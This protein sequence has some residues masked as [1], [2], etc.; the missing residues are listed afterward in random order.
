MTKITTP[1]NPR[2]LQLLLKGYKA[3]KTHY[4]VNGFTFGFRIGFV[5]V[6]R[7]MH[8]PN[9]KSAYTNSAATSELL[10]KELAADRLLGPFQKIPFSTAF[11][12]PLSVIPKKS[13]N[14]FRLIHDLSFP[15]NQ[16]VNSGIPPHS[17]TVHYESFDSAIKYIVTQG[18]QVLLMKCD[19]LNAFRIVPV[20]PDDRPLLG[21]S[22][23][24]K[25][26]F[27]KCLT[28]GCGSSCRIFEEFST[29]IKF[30]LLRFI[31]N[32]HIVKV[33]DDFLIITSATHPCPSLAYRQMFAVFQLLGV[34]L[35]LDKCVAPCSVLTFLGLE[36]NVI[37]QSVKLPKDK[38]D[39]CLGAVGRL[40]QQSKAK[41]QQV[42]SV[43]GLLQW[44]CKAIVP[45][46]AFLRRLY[47]ALKH[48]KNKRHRM[49]VTAEMKDD[50]RVWDCFLR[51]FNGRSLM[52]PQHAPE[53]VIY[54][55]ASKS[56]GY[57][58]VT[59]TG[60]WF[61]GLWPASWSPLSI[62]VLELAPIVLAVATWGG[63]L[64]HKVLHVYS[65]NLGLVTSINAQSAKDRT[66]MALIRRLV[67][68]LLHFNILIVARH[69]P[70][71]NNRCADALSRG[72]IS[73]FQELCPIAQDLPTPIPP[74]WQLDNWTPQSPIS[75]SRLLHHGPA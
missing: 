60:R 14:S 67:Y 3:R 52:L 62:A 70:G 42:Q 22:W 57:G 15:K 65:D 40:L 12:S 55:D 17:R 34:P 32:A 11:I 58:C 59:S 21:L 41:V 66:L 46:R 74:L 54:A 10:C 72:K 23:D 36:I 27:D 30:I 37:E 25:F 28:L 73:V 4:L 7:S 26:Y 68:L 18:P 31:K 56:V 20:H 9:H 16:S 2:A 51:S 8:S 64:A 43:C 24:N 44:A 39:K 75:F 45:G 63:D 38:L 13:A 69:I 50:L 5:G 35:A 29:A 6:A 19:I 33:L 48:R 49:R 53:C 61:C 71:I 1:V 47:D